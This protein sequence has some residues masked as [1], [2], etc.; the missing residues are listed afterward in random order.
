MKMFKTEV[1]WV[2]T[3]CSSREAVA[4]A[5][6]LLNLPFDPEGGGDMLFRNILLFPLNPECCVLFI[7]RAFRISKPI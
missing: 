1:F 4:S 5:G 6:F 3:L 2:V 7:V